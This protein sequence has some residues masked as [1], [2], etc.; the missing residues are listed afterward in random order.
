[1]TFKGIDTPI[2][3][4]RLLFVNNLWTGPGID[5][6]AHGRVQRD[7]EYNRRPIPRILVPDTRKY[8][9]V[10][11][12]SGHDA[13]CFF[14]ALPNRGVNSASVWICFLV[15]LEKLYPSVAGRLATEYAH[16]DVNS[17]ILDGPF[18][19]TG[20]VTDLSAFREYDLTEVSDNLQPFY[21][22]RFNTNIVYQDN[23]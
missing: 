16:A 5:F 3:Y 2:E 13:M 20:I 10:L 17:L 8:T 14:D 7:E 4:Q 22:F 11:L 1:M 12:D 9:D 18:T 21:L 6:V 15:N 23:C 19:K